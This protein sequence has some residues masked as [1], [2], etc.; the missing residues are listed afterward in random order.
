MCDEFKENM[1][2][3]LEYITPKID[4]KNG[5]HL[6]VNFDLRPDGDESTGDSLFA[7]DITYGQTSR[8]CT[9]ALQRR[10]DRK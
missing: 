7:L 5:G 6:N 9:C 8:V 1:F 2:V 4:S 3:H 10:F